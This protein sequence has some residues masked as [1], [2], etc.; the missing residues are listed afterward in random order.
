MLRYDADDCRCLLLPDADAAALELLAPV[1]FEDAPRAL[2]RLRRLCLTNEDRKHLA[3]CLPA[4]LLALIGAAT[5]DASLLNFERFVQAVDDR[6]RLFAELARRPRSVEIMFR[7]FVGSQFLTDLLLRNPRYLEQLSEHK[8]LAEFKSRNQFVAETDAAIANRGAFEEKLDRLRRHQQWELLRLAACDTFNLMDLKAVTLQLSLLADGLVQCCLALAARELKL[9]A[10][11]FSVLAFGKLGGEELNYSSDI[12]LAFVCKASAEKYWGLGQKLIRAINAVTR[13]GFL[14]RVDM[15]LRPWG[16]SGPLVTTVDAYVEYLHR[17]G[18]PWEKQAFLKARPI[19]GAFDV[20]NELLNRIES[21]VFSVPPDEVCENVRDMKRQIERKISPADRGWAEVKSGPGGIRDI[22]FLT[23][24]LQLIHGRQQPD[25]RS[26]NTLDGLVRLAEREVLLPGEFRH[27]SSAYVFQ[28][29]VE[30]SLQL[31]HNLQQHMLPNSDRELEYLARRLD[32]PTVADFLGH[33]HDHRRYVREICERRLRPSSG[34][35]DFDA[36]PPPPVVRHLGEAAANYS[37][38]FDPEQVERHLQLLDRLNDDA[39]VVAHAVELPDRRWELTVVGF[40]QLGDLSLICGLLFAFGFNIESGFVFTGTDVGKDG[41]SGKPHVQH[42]RRK[43]VNVFVV[44]RTVAV[45]SRTW[46]EYERDLTQLLSLAAAGQIG[47]AQGQLA[48]RVGA[49]FRES[50]SPQRMLPVEIAIDNDL[51]AEATVLHIRADD[52][53]GFLYELSNALAVSGVSVQRVLIHSHGERVVDTLFVTKAD[54]AKIMQPNQLHELRAAI[55]LTKHFTHLLPN[56]PNPESALLHF[57]GLL[58]NLFRQERWLDQLASLQQPEVLQALARLLGGSDFLWQDFLRLQH[59]NLFP[60]VTDVAGLEE[61]R[62]LTTLRRML[63]EELASASGPEERRRILNAFKDREMFRVDMRHILDLQTQFGMFSQELTWVAEAV[64]ESTWRLCEEELRTT[65]GRPQLPDG[66]EC[67]LAICALGK[68]GGRELGFASDI[69]LLFVYE[70][71]GRTSGPQCISNADYFVRLVDVFRRSIQ[72]RQ[73]GIF[74]IDL[75]MRPYGKA[76]SLAVSRE[77]FERYFGPDGPAWPYERQALVKLRAVA[78][79]R[80]FGREIQDLRDR[81]VYT[82]EPFDLA[83]MRGMRERQTTEL[84]R[85]GTFNAKLSPGGLVDCEY[86]VQGL[87][88]TYGRDIPGLRETN[89]RFAMRALERAGIVEDRRPLRDAY[90]F[91]RRV[92]DALRMVRGDA[93][94]LTVPPAD[95][96]EFEFLARRL[97]Y[98]SNVAQLQRDLDRH[99]RVVHEHQRLLHSLI[100]RRDSVH[101]GGAVSEDD[102]ADHQKQRHER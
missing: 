4:V 72:A 57:R 37:E 52:T 59:A 40:D 31:M 79:D 76:G 85:A 100:A 24:A 55:V 93:R 38:L 82:G 90:R 49:A 70:L 33:Y 77:V 84:V 94:D 95:S 20:A 67:R 13:E 68:F 21:T 62:D 51:A 87:Q 11:D 60:V 1:G 92:I 65:Y 61:P 48:R 27:L 12:D 81:L 18:R 3:P 15:R 2:E 19:A 6:S 17:H 99:T 88:I 42:L 16:K 34:R 50:S 75:R 30:H 97:G 41:L 7:L 80:A 14:Y 83:A 73:R 78:G 101:Q 89:T 36:P 23:Q 44:S 46:S 56:S 63:A 28:R 102:G 32:Y 91:L 29:T 54:G 64:V 10:A 66:T 53:P 25:V 45:N 26:I 43:F 35:A 8:R 74:E 69:E 86:F 22:E 96:D 47:E 39:S 5:P 9:D 98:E 71:E 58:E